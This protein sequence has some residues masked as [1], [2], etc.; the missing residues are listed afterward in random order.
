VIILFLDLLLGIAL[1]A[2]SGMLRPQG[3]SII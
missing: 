1:E 2:V 3:P